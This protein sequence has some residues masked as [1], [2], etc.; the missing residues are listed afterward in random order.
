MIDL[1]SWLE[2]KRRRQS[3]LE[4]SCEESS[5]VTKGCSVAVDDDDELI[6]DNFRK[7]KN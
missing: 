3:R 4:E 7:E 6:N 5:E 1:V 2:R